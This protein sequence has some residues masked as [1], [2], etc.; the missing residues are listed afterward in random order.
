MR[1]C[2]TRIIYD[3]Y[4]C[5]TC[6]KRRGAWPFDGGDQ[7]YSTPGNCSTP[8]PETL[9]LVF[10][11]GSKIICVEFP[12]SQCLAAEVIVGCDFMDRFMEA[13]YPCRKAIDLDDAS[14]IP[15]TGRPL[16]R[17]PNALP[18]PV[19]QKLARAGGRTSPRL[20]V[21]KPI[22]MEPAQQTFVSVNSK[23]HGLMLLQP[24]VKLYRKSQ[25]FASDRYVQVEPNCEFRVLVSNFGI[26]PYW[27]VKGQMISMLP[28]HL[29]VDIAS[30]VGVAE[31]LD[32]TDE[33]ANEIQQE[34]QNH[35]YQ[36]V[37]DASIARNPDNVDL[38]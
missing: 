9:D 15:I 31:M 8:L 17:T 2:R 5:D 36:A 33:E 37:E 6:V 26:S 38:S 22:A 24:H 21:T 16:R 28:P 34:F 7:A 12:I 19:S 35:V 3:S 25:I 20:S 23:R 30:T 11:N 27:L 4:T 1:T 18:F 10:R 13:V 14:L 32:L 29:T